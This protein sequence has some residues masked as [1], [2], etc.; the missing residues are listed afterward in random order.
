M[1]CFQ[2]LRLR[3]HQIRQ[4]AGFTLVELLVVIAIIGILIGMLLPAVQAVR[5]AA[6]RASCLNNLKQVGLALH[7]YESSFG[8]YPSGW[9]EAYAI[10]DP[11]FANYRWGWATAILPYMEQNNLYETYDFRMGL[12]DDPTTAELDFDSA[13]VVESYLCPSDP[14]PRL[15]PNVHNGIHAKMNYGGSIGNDFL[16][17]SIV[18]PITFIDDDGSSYRLGDSGYF[19]GRSETKIAT[20]R[21][22]TS[23]TVMVGERGGTDPDTK[24]TPNVL[25]RIGLVKH[26]DSNGFPEVGN[27]LNQ[28]CFNREV[29]YNYCI[30]LDPPVELELGAEDFLINGSFNAYQLGYSSD[31]PGGCNILF[32]DG[33]VVFVPETINCETFEQLLQT[34]DGEVIDMSQIR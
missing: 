28:G 31:H 26:E 29:W 30:G 7:N 23:N 5:E 1:T 19:Y 32:G 18:D 13:T 9:T 14:M 11:L 10:D 33:S 4:R 8:N 27:Q 12:W 2:F 6:R 20:I 3:N 21:D 34:Q 25:I 22:G 24:T 15:N 17:N 16:N